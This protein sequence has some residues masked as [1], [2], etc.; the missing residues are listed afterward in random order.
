MGLAPGGLMRQHI[1]EDPY[2]MDAWDTTHRSR[3]FVHILNSLQHRE[4]MGRNPPTKAPHAADYAKAGL[5]WFEY[6][7]D[8]PAVDGS[9]KLAGLISVAANWFKKNKVPMPENDPLG[10]AK[11]VSLRASRK[12]IVRESDF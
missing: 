8:A 2:G 6:Y 5:P 12:S 4:V 9:S 11:T 1:Y 7:A 3:C 10:Q